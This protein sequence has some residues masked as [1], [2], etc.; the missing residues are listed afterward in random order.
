MPITPNISFDNLPIA[1]LSI[2]TTYE[3]GTRGNSGDDPLSKL[4]GCENQG[5]FRPVGTRNGSGTKFCV[6]YSD[7]SKE[8]WP[9]KIDTET[10]RF[11][12][13][14]D[15]RKQ[16]NDIHDTPKKGNLILR[17][18]FDELHKVNRRS[19]PPFFVFTKGT[20]GRDVVFRGLAVPGS[21]ELNETQ[22]LTIVRNEHP[23]G[24]ILNYR[25]VFT[26]LD[27]PTI[28]RKW[29]ED[30]HN[31]NPLS[32]NA[33][34]IWVDWV[35]NGLKVIEKPE[36]YIT[37]PNPKFWLFN[38]YYSK[39]PV[40]W[41][42]SKQLGV[43]AM[44]YEYGRENSSSVT[45]HINLIKQIS[46]GDYI[47]SYT[48]N[49]GFLGYG[50]VTH[51]FFEE[52]DQQNYIKA[53]GANW[54][55]RVG[56]DWTKALDVPVNYSGSNFVDEVGIMG[57]PVMGSSTI[58]EITED[59]FEFSKSLI[60][61]AP[62]S[63]IKVKLKRMFNSTELVNHVYSY[64]ES[65][66]FYYTKEE[67][68]NLFFAIK[69]KPFVILS[70]ISGTGKTKL[71]QWFTEAVGATEE[72]RQFTLIPVRPDWNDGSDLLGYVDIKGDFKPGP[73]TKVI[74]RARKNPDLPYFV[75][76]DEMNLARVEHYFSDVLSVMESR[77]WKNQKMVTST[78][79]TAEMSG[80]EDIT[81]PTNLYI[82][83]TVNMDET[84]HPFSKKV[85]DRANTIEFNRVDLTNLSFLDELEEVDSIEVSNQSFQSK[86]LHLKDLYMEDADFVKK[87]TA[88][89]E[90]INNILLPSNNHFGYR[91]RD[92]ICFY[93][94]YNDSGN[95]MKYEEAFDYCILQKI[96]PRI[97]GSDEPT[98][99]LLKGLY[100]HFTGRI[101]S[102][103]SE[104]E[105][106]LKQAKYPKSAAKVL[107]MLRRLRD[108]FTSFWIS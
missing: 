74:E 53:T 66:G 51:P 17:Y 25:A 11:I 103:Q 48:G 37:N 75:L 6:I 15:K 106:E 92:E 81:L 68:T 33:P 3:G 90:S 31:N 99:Q 39:E 19:I 7:F 88:E 64:I 63:K 89:L 104:Y 4:M 72:N 100:K 95:L 56:V 36:G 2:G 9:N 50:K 35:N 96:L 108:G 65:K 14:G 85:L 59:G 20:K 76:L 16:G 45:K 91:I 55:Q 24:E 97:A 12:Y 87:V 5:G 86:Y 98:E 73:L 8:E 58:F 29:I 94:A 105:E 43:A 28:S 54:R 84:T 41:E 26:I 32:E 49:K 30:L 67:V 38:S 60:D 23:E 83:G 82:L 34:T 21:T 93:L 10:G 69:T 79:I 80:K 46:V 52:N 18:S 77:K 62:Y 107:E 27:I 22:D 42:K 47:V 44:Q 1:D 40:V 102:E 101:Y 57:S 61:G 13:Y 70:G 78:L 71:V